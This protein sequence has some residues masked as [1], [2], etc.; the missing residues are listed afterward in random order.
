MSRKSRLCAGERPSHPP[1]YNAAMPRLPLPP[2]RHLLGALIVL[3]GVVLA[4]LARDPRAPDLALKPWAHFVSD[5]LHTVFLGGGIGA[6]LLTAWRTKN[7]ALAIRTAAV[8]GAETALF[9]IAKLITWFGL[10][11]LYPRPSGT[12][13]GFPSG[14]TAA[15][16]ALAWLLSD[17]FGARWSP[18]FYAIAAA[19][20][21]SRVGDG[22]HFAYQVAAGALLGYGVAWAMSGRFGARS[23]GEVT[24]IQDQ[25][26]TDQGEPRH[27]E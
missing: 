5:T 24:E 3:V 7:P 13:G 25:T 14:H 8:M 20:A 4:F 19:V 17:R 27:A 16:V 15:N 2:R 11:H 22:A 10:H 1:V 9:E 12:D 26:Q 23:V 6:L 18:V 21:W